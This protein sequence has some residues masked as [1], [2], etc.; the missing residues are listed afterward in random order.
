MDPHFVRYHDQCGLESE[1]RDPATF[2]GQFDKAIEVMNREWLLLYVPVYVYCI[3]DS[4]R[5]TVDANEYVRLSEIE[6]PATPVY[7]MG[8]LDHSFLD[9]RHPWVAVVWSAF[10]PGLGQMYNHRLP[11]AVSLLFWWIVVSHLSH[12]L[13]GI[14][15]TLMEEFDLARTSL[16]PQWRCIYHRPM[17][18][19]CLTPMWIQSSL[20]KLM[21][22]SRLSICW[23]TIK[24]LASK[25]LFPSNWRFWHVYHL[26]H[27]SFCL[28]GQS[29]TGVAYARH[30]KTRHPCRAPH[31]KR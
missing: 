31:P 20:E 14:H 28:F 19:R 17:G 29:D 2:M 4:W 11:S 16:V 21:R 5:S 27:L 3:W 18:S 7:I 8:G 24:T 13:T 25:C 23:K 9:K 30:S 10:M 15:Y 12:L 1:Y 22:S 6:D 26:Y